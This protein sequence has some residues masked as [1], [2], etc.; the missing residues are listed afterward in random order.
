MTAGRYAGS[1]TLDEKDGVDV[2]NNK[3]EKAGGKSKLWG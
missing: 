3:S 2:Y 1:R